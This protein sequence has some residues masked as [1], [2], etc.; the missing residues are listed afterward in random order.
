MFVLIGCTVGQEADLGNGA[1]SYEHPH[2]SPYQTI[3]LQGG[4]QPVLEL[5]HV[6]S[7]LG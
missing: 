4:L 1:P 6:F 3:M 5:S 2:P 7:P